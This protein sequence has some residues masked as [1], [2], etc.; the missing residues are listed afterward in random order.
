M[1]EAN[2]DLLYLIACALNGEIPALERVRTMDLEALY[3][4]AS[5]HSLT[6]ITA[7]ALEPA[8]ALLSAP[9]AQ[10]AQWKEAKEKAIRKNLLLDTERRRILAYMEQSGIW[11]MPLKGSVL[12]ELYPQYGMRE[13]ADNDILFDSTF[14]HRMR[15]FM[16]AS[17]YTVRS[18]GKGNDDDYVK[19]P[20]YHFELH[21]HL[22]GQAHD[23]VWEAYYRDIQPRL[24][25]QAGTG[26]GFRFR[27]EDFYVFMIA[28]AR[29]HDVLGG[30]GLRFLVDI[31]V[32]IQKKGAALDWHYVNGELEK[33]AIGDFGHRCRALADQLF[34]SPAHFDALRLMEDALALLTRLA[35]S[36][37]YGTLQNRVENQLS[38]MASEGRPI[39]QADKLRYL[40]KRLFPDLQWF[41][42]YAPFFGKHRLLIPFFLVYRAFRGLFSR[43]QALKDELRAVR[44]AGKELLSHKE[45]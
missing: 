24:L 42:T 40:W 14:R 33:L 22:F 19:P 9:A 32:F 38:A 29:K 16:E 43:R 21:R 27:D 3:R 15:R 34:S 17:G 4:A 36:G 45:P 7:M 30:T 6:A 5:F 35:D 26:F 1:T 44:D 11:Y 20:V 13:M 12:Q 10:A 31:Y 37:A 39:T 28:H 2:W 23:P 18:Y 25:R 41:R 8:G